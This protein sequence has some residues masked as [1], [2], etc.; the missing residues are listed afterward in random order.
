[1]NNFEEDISIGG[2][3]AQ[4]NFNTFWKIIAG[5]FF[6]YFLFEKIVCKYNVI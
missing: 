2:I 4:T 3:G 5:M 1:M 6:L